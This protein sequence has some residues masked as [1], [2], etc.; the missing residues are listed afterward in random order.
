MKRSRII[1]ILTLLFAVLMF[2]NLYGRKLD[3]SVNTHTYDGY[4]AP[5]NAVVLWIKKA[6][7]EFIKTL[8]VWGPNVNF[9]LKNWRDASGL[10][11]EGWYDGET[12]ATKKEH[13][14]V[15]VTWDCKDSTGKAVPDGDYEFWVEFLEDDYFWQVMNPNEE[16]LGKVTK[17]T[18][19]I[20]NSDKTANGID[21]S[22]YFSNFKADYKANVGIIAGHDRIT[23]NQSYAIQYN[24]GMKQIH[25]QIHKNTIKTPET[26]YLASL[27]G[28]IVR[29][30]SLRG[31]QSMV[32]DLL[33]SKHHYLSSGIYFLTA[34]SKQGTPFSL[35]YKISLLR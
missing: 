8:H 6:S 21:T 22:K 31:S 14:T 2:S 24:K 13:N 30:F 28:K 34:C 3:I 19:K 18:I 16:Y 15:K 26:F 17:G 27:S 5:N 32:I 9:M 25:I 23:Y 4:R 20:D 7:G 11:Q 29:T 35:G 10:G 1:C 33:D 12:S